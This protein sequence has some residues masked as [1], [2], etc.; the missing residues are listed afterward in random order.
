MLAQKAHTED[1]TN[2]LRLQAEFGTAPVG[3]EIESWDWA[4]DEFGYKTRYDFTL[5]PDEVITIWSDW[6]VRPDVAGFL[7][8]LSHDSAEHCVRFTVQQGDSFTAS[9]WCRFSEAHKLLSD[10]LA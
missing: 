4:E 1:M 9:T 10:F 8:T 7:H 2:D 6:Q 3:A 5:I